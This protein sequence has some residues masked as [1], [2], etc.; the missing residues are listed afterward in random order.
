[1]IPL[2]ALACYATVVAAPEPDD[3]TARQLAGAARSDDFE[4]AW[5]AIEQLRQRGADAQGYL[6]D[7]LEHQLE[8]HARIIAARTDHVERMG[9]LEERFARWESDRRD[10]WR[11]L[12]RMRSDADVRKAL[13]NRRRLEQ[14]F[15]QIDRLAGF[16]LDLAELVLQG[17]QLA[18]LYEDVTD[19]AATETPTDAA[20]DAAIEAATEALGLSVKQLEEVLRFDPKRP[21]RS[22]ATQR[23]WFVNLCGRVEAYNRGQAELCD[24]GEFA[25]VQQINAY[26]RA[27]GVKPLEID[28][29]LTQAA[30]RYSKSMVDLGFQ[31]HRSPE[32]GLETPHRRM[33]AA[34]HPRPFS[35]NVV[36]GST[37]ATVMFNALLES[38]SHHLN[39][40]NRF[41]TQIGVGRWDDHW[42]QN[43]GMGPWLMLMDASR[44]DQVEVKGEPLGPQR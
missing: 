12:R 25:M 29:R 37:N 16:E 30:R 32:Q 24:G 17:R 6:V 40:L 18:A 42:T 13:G 26:R 19:E 7:A 28:P 21:P 43:Y 22:R 4:R 20:I 31:G 39:T 9:S 8:R 41:S 1:M 14:Q 5:A 3:L 44:R 15:A 38:P 10:A 23:L 2:M 36:T 33:I 34:G 11:T 35:E 27:M